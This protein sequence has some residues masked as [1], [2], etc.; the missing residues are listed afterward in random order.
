M[1][2]PPIVAAAAVLEKEG[3]NGRATGAGAATPSVT[4]IS[5]LS[6]SDVPV[7]VSPQA[8]RVAS[9]AMLNS[10]KCFDMRRSP[11]TSEADRPRAGRDPLRQPGGL[12]RWRPVALR[13]GLAAGVPSSKEMLMGARARAAAIEGPARRLGYPYIAAA[14]RL[15]ILKM[16]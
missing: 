15:P 1:D 4:T 9:A 8:A 10:A 13:T 16:E 3:R 14:K 12:P 6:G 7:G 2:T 5:P 11:V